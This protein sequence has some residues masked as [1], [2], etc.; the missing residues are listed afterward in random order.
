[1]PRSLPYAF[2]THSHAEHS[3]KIGDIPDARRGPLETLALLHH[4]ITPQEGPMSGRSIIA[5]CRRRAARCVIFAAQVPLW[6]ARSP[7]SGKLQWTGTPRIGAR[8]S[9]RARQL[10]RARSSAPTRTRSS[11]RALITDQVVRGDPAR[12][13][14]WGHTDGRSGGANEHQRLR[15]RV[16]LQRP[17]LPDEALAEAPLGRGRRT[18]IIRDALA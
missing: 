7:A 2:S 3:A 13:Q 5:A 1:M 10:D 9:S 16:G 15:L 4:H 18:W 17:R 14:N 11:P 8:P 12:V 6:P